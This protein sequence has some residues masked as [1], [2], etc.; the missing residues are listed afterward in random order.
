MS[1]YGCDN[2][3]PR[4]M[5][6]KTRPIN[7]QQPEQSAYRVVVGVGHVVGRLDQVQADA[8]VV[9]GIN[10]GQIEQVLLEAL[11][12][13]EQVDRLGLGVVR[14]MKGHNFRH[15]VHEVVEVVLVIFGVG[16]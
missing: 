8:L 16:D 2:E 9:V 5:G 15:H 1:G 12:L 10:L 14:H 4:V 7:G 13:D 6:P 3:Y 11:D